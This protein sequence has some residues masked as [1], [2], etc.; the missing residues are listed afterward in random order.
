MNSKTK[1]II[2]VAVALAIAGGVVYAQAT[3]LLSVPASVNVQTD[4]TLVSTP[5]TVTF[6]NLVQ[7]QSTQQSI[8]VTNTGDTATDTLEVATENLAEGLTLTHNLP[9]VLNAGQSVSVTFTLSANATATAG[10]NNFNIIVDE[11][12]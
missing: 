5:S 6:G 4:A 12:A 11:V 10:I 3:G 7:G 2:I 8:T 9:S 1:W